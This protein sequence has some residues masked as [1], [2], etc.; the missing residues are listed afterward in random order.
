MGQVLAILGTRR[1]PQPPPQPPPPLLRLPVEL[2]LEICAQ[3]GAARWGAA[4]TTALAVTCKALFS[5]LSSNN[6]LP[7]LQGRDLASFLFQ[8]ERDLGDDFYLCQECWKLHRF[9]ADWGPEDL[10]SRTGCR[11]IQSRSFYPYRLG[12][13]HLRLVMN[14]HRLGGPKGLPLRNLA[15]QRSS[16][17]VDHE[18]PWDHK[19]CARVIDG[20]LFLHSR[21]TLRGYDEH[22]LRRAAGHELLYICDHVH[23]HSYALARPT[24]SFKPRHGIAGSCKRC[25]TDYTSKIE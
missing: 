15:V 16:I 3:V 6:K 8:L 17:G 9:C 5:V 1:N 24:F 22:D 4:S 11:M 21:H 7:R 19:W 23:M 13:Y 18:R 10:S 2:V 25:L 20:E 12:W 14:R